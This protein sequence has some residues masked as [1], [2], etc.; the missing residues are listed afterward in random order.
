MPLWTEDRQDVL[1]GFLK[2]GRVI[3]PEEFDKYVYDN[4]C[5]PPEE[6]PTL[7]EYQREVKHLCRK[8]RKR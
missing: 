5:K 3:S 4:D 6:K 8:T 1:E 2:Y 7:E